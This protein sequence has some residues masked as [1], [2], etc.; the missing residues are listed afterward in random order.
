MRN[1][2]DPKIRADMF[3]VLR[4]LKVTYE[5]WHTAGGT[6]PPWKGAASRDS[7]CAGTPLLRGDEV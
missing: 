6:P 2:D 4:Q 1:C 7:R 3:H 5:S